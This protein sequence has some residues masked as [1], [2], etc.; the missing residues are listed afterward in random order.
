MSST[1]LSSRNLSHL[2]PFPDIDFRNAE[3]YWHAAT[4]K[5]GGQMQ[6]LI[7]PDRLSRASD[8]REAEQAA[9]QDAALV[10]EAKHSPVAFAALYQRYVASVFRYIH[11]RTGSAADAEDLTSDAIAN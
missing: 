8:E 4:E 10:K 9:A 5:R 7:L 3:A 2:R 6:E 11:V 1:Q